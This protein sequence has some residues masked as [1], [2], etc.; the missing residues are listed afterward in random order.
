MRGID[1]TALSGLLICAS[2]MGSGLL[3]SNGTFQFVGA[4]FGWFLAAY[5][6]L[7]YVVQA[8]RI[9][10][11]IAV[12]LWGTLVPVNFGI[13]LIGLSAFG[14]HDWEAVKISIGVFA[15]AMVAGLV[16][17]K[18]SFTQHRFFPAGLLVVLVSPFYEG[19]SAIWTY[20][21]VAVASLLLAI[22]LVEL[23]KRGVDSMG[24]SPISK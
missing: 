24:V 19:L 15:S 9:A 10:M 14:I 18:V 7:R 6:F 20:I 1:L 4:F 22:G 3:L 11:R 16:L 17:G 5:T 2:A 21:Y 23:A 8:V 13:A 12:P